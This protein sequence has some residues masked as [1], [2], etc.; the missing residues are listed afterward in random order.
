MTHP[1]IRKSYSEKAQNIKKFNIS[2][3]EIDISFVLCQPKIV[4]AL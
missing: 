3:V 4:V 1:L 2:C